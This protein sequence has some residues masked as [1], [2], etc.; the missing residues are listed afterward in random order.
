M[1]LQKYELSVIFR[2]GLLMAESEDPV[3][4]PAVNTI[5][6]QPPLPIIPP[7]SEGLCTCVFSEK[8]HHKHKQC[9]FSL[10]EHTED[11]ADELILTIWTK[12]IISVIAIYLLVVS[13][14]A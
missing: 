8:E 11:G 14:C 1:A 6:T 7:C 5:S 10:R 12:L 9:A 4:S 13:I 2:E 3:T